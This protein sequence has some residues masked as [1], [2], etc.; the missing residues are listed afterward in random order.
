[1]K[2]KILALACLTVIMTVVNTQAV[3]YTPDFSDYIFPG[4]QFTVDGATNNFFLTNYGITFDHAYLYKDSRDLFD[5]IGAANGYVS[6]NNIPNITATINFAE[7]TDFV[8]FDYLAL[9][10]TVYRAFDS[11]NNLLASYNANPGNGTYTFAG[12]IS[13]LTFT[14]T[15]GYGTVSSLTYNY[16]GITDGTNHDLPG[17]APVPEPSTMLLV[18]GGLAGLA[19]W[20]RKQQ[21]K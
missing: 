13:S 7:T 4:T 15:G 1:M 6:E 3:I 2:L 14:T 11:S 12:N 8:T 10:S 9:F 16:D 17:T 19:F 20:R 18:G 5:G 21:S